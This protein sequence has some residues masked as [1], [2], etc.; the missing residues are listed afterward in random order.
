ML[1]VLGSVPV[2]AA[3]AALLPQ[4]GCRSPLETAFS[5]V[6]DRPHHPVAPVANHTT[7]FDSSA[8][9]LL[10]EISER[11][12]H[13]FLEKS[14]PST[15]IVLDR[16]PAG[17]Q[18]A[19]SLAPP[20]SIAATGFGISA[21]CVAAEHGFVSPAECERRI[22]RTLEFVAHR[23]PHEHGFLPHYLDARTGALA[24]GSEYSSIDTALFLCGALH[25][26][27]FLNSARADALASEIYGR[28]DW[29][30]MQGQPA[31]PASPAAMPGAGAARTQAATLCM[32]W[33][34]QSGFLQSRWDSYSECMLMYLLA[35]GS[36]THPIAPD[37]WGQIERNTYDYG[38]IRFISSFGAL[39]I[40]QY[41]HVWVDM[42]NM[43]D[44]HA[45]YFQ[46]SI[47]AIRAHKTWCMLQHG[48]YPWIDERTWGFSASDTAHQ[49]YAAWA[50][51]PVVGSWDGTLAPH[52]AGGS[53]PLIPEECIV[54]LKA[55]REH[56]PR[57][58]G[59]YGFVNA[60]NPGANGGH[61][62]FDRDIIASDLALILLMAENQRTGAV[63]STFMRNPEIGR[64]MEAV[65][66]RRN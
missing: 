66:F 62:W 12:S 43:H 60:F 25:A 8:A 50:A 18:D 58:F 65:G 47:A 16:A 48:Q 11:G 10:E 21:L 27:R 29:P 30:W 57:C 44:G 53:L 5:P 41:L 61:G 17:G 59:R 54:V 15:G 32:G 45:D 3:G 2:V 46:N 33:L 6:A 20:G 19:G 24:P 35:I 63:R 7:N 56:H 52:A 51:P 39:F 37:V 55:M 34:P 36:P 49:N 14:H 26:R 31:T 23:V 40:H 42:R 9:A 64:A 28:V 1:R 13:F 38:G 22:L 4:A